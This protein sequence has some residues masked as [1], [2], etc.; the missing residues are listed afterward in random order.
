MGPPKLLNSSR[1]KEPGCEGFFERR[2]GEVLF[3]SGLA[4]A[5]VEGD[6][7]FRDIAPV[8]PCPNRVTIGK[9]GHRCEA[10]GRT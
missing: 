1:A 6:I 8:S 7:R 4:G 9:N 10:L 3:L 2:F 5:R